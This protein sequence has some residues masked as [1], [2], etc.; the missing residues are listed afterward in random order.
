[1]AHNSLLD[2]DSSSLVKTL[3]TN[4]TTG[5]STQQATRAL[6]HYGFNEIPEKKPHIIVK[7]LKKFWGVT[8]WMLELIIVLSWILNRRI[9]LYIVSALLVSNALISFMEEWVASN[10]CGKSQ[11]EAPYQREGLRDGQWVLVPARQLAP[12]DIISIK[13]GDFVP[14]DIKLVEGTLTVDE[15]ALTGESLP[16]SK[17]VNDAVY[18]GSIIRAGEA[19]GIVILT[20]TRTSFGKTVE[21]VQ[22]A[23]PRPHVESIISSVSVRLLLV[24]VVLVLITSIV[25][26]YKGISL[27]EI[28]PLMLVLLLGAIPVA[29]PAMFTVS[30]ALG[31]Q[32]LLKKNIL[33]VRLNAI[34]DAAGLTVLCIDKTGTLTLNQ[35][36]IADSVPL[37]GYNTRDVILC[38]ALASE[39]ESLDPI[40]LAFISQAQKEHLLAGYTRSEFV[41]F[42]QVTKRT[43]ALVEKGGEEF[44]VYKGALGPMIKKFGLNEQQSTELMS[45]ADAFAKKGFRTIAVARTINSRPTIIGLVALQDPA[46]PESKQVL[47]DLKDLGITIKVLTGD[48]LSIAQQIAKTVGLDTQ[49]VDY[50]AYR[51]KIKADPTLAAQIITDTTLFAEIYPED[52]YNIV[53]ILQN[54]GQI[55][56]MTGDGVNDAPALQQAEV[57]IA[58]DD[59]TDV[60]KKSASVVLTHPGLFNI[61]ELIKMGRLVFARV[62]TWILDKICRTILKTGFVVVAFFITGIYV[63]SSTEMLLLVFMIDFVTLSLATDKETIS[64]TPCKWDLPGLDRLAL[65]LG[66]AM[67]IEALGLLYVGMH[68]LKYEGEMLHTFSFEILFYFALFSA[69]IVR[70]KKHFWAS[71][72]SK[73]FLFA[74]LA[75]GIAAFFITTYGLLGMSVIPIHITL[76]VIAYASIF[77][78]L[79]NDLLKVFFHKIKRKAKK[80]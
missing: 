61:D 66:I 23:A 9:D 44:R 32:E 16:Q 28:L 33:V 24:V 68:Y 45:Y 62:N 17:G 2:Q 25:S 51:D 27:V 76:L 5:L 75:D 22:L 78:L 50:S 69:F 10:A 21:L 79:I 58:V 47:K 60:A 8:A 34:E 43:E 31:S 35:L 3:E 54:E 70:E 30:M 74:I 38:G 40:D 52:K 11:K 56:G 12:G 19:K 57:G 67:V 64:K 73:T 15:S 4:A 55:V 48:A 20:G 26:V 14:A 39:D 7:L 72:P 71:L 41:P 80:A 18:S 77:S 37:H 13:M 42:D 53:K 1:M 59:A 29:L 65:F 46:R 63:I 36:A 49:A 6:Q